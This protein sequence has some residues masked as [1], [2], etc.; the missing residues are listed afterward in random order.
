MRAR[1]HP[2]V[3]LESLPQ[4]RSSSRIGVKIGTFYFPTK[5]Q[6]EAY[7]R[8]LLARYSQGQILNAGDEVFVMHLLDLH[9]NRDCIVGDG[10]KYVKVQHLDSGARRF[11]LVRKDGTYRDFSWRYAV[12]PTNAKRQVHRVCRSMV[13][14]QI[15][16]FRDAAFGPLD[17]IHCAYTGEL[18]EWQDADVDHAPPNTFEVLVDNW[19]KSLGISYE[20]VEIVPSPNYQE[21][22]K[23]LDPVLA[24]T[25]PQYHQEHA[26]LR[27]VSAFANRSLLRRKDAGGGIGA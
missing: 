16:L 18:I 8:A 14:R 7:V 3:P 24:Q 13:R 10:I 6:A 15:S 12:H 4:R 26:K 21:E 11:L 17:A 25:W 23:F 1:K 27:V 19:L 9:P 22:S 20:D 2:E 5:K